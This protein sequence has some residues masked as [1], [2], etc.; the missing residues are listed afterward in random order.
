MASTNHGCVLRG[1]QIFTERIGQSGRASGGATSVMEKS[2]KAAADAM[3]IRPRRQFMQSEPEQKCDYVERNG[4]HHFAYV[5]KGEGAGSDGA[6][7]G[8]AVGVG[9]VSSGQTNVRAGALQRSRA[10]LGR[11]TNPE[12]TGSTVQDGGE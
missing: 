9:L 2:G 3:M 4:R 8:D 5:G 7:A 6:S 10:D 12:K 11:H 1:Q